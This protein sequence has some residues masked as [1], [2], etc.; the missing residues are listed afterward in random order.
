MITIISNFGKILLGKALCR[1]NGT[2]PFHLSSP[3]P[4]IVPGFSEEEFK[5]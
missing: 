5:Y 2:G 3:F 1:R 4:D